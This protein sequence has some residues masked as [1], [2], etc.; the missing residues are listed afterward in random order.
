MT[1]LAARRRELQRR[2]KEAEK[3]V[4]RAGRD[5][6]RALADWSAAATEDGLLA[7]AEALLDCYARLVERTP[8]DSGRA[9]AGWH[10]A[11]RPDDWAPAP[12]EYK[13]RLARLVQEQSARILSLSRADVI[14]IMN[15]VAY[16]H[17]LETGRARD[18]QGGA[19]FA[20]L[21][22]EARSRLEAVAARGRTGKV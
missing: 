9:A 4:C 3:R 18:G 11:A 19:F 16:I 1:E 10:I 17:A 15:N 6:E 21:A 12:G 2:M 13:D 7:F 22:E 5:L 20:L 14:F 8:R